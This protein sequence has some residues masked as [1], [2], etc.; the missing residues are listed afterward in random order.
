M[1]PRTETVL[2]SSGPSVL[3]VLRLCSKEQSFPTGLLSPRFSRDGCVHA[4]R[5]GRSWTEVLHFPQLLL[6]TSVRLHVQ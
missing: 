4:W 1:R 5:D 2:L 3:N 6:C